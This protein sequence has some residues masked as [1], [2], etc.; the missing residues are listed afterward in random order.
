MTPELWQRVEATLDA[1]DEA[2]VDR[3]GEV[4]DRLCADDDVLRREVERLLDVATE[5]EGFLDAPIWS[6]PPTL[7]PA[8]ER[9]GPYQ[10]ESSI[11]RGGMGEVFLARRADGA[12]DQQVAVKLLDARSDDQDL[13]RRFR[14]ERQIL[15][16]LDHP[17]IARLIDGGTVDDGRPY[18]VMEHV[19]GEP[20]VAWCRRHALDVDARLRLVLKVCAAVQ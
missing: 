17:N 12:F 3:R 7:L 19:E 2:P 9:F 5:A 14:D 1:I 10:A 8:P 4:L 18:L 13:V 16:G 15:A 6:P 11:G 20:I